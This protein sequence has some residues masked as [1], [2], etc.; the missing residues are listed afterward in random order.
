MLEVGDLALLVPVGRA[1]NARAQRAIVLVTRADRHVIEATV[2]D[3]GDAASTLVHSVTSCGSPRSARILHCLARIRLTLVR[4]SGARGSSRTCHALFVLQASVRLDTLFTA[5]A[6]ASCTIAP[7]VIS[8]L[9]QLLAL[10][11]VAEL[12]N[13]VM[14]NEQVGTGATAAVLIV[15]RGAA[16]LV[17]LMLVLET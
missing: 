6:G 17:M 3:A 8:R 9:L 4:A 12:V 7:L 1:L 10:F 15:Y 13:V 16:R 2:G 11:K 5:D 14:R